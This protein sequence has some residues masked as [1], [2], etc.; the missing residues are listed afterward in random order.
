MYKTQIE[1]ILTHM[2]KNRQGITSLQSYNIYNITR[3]GA[4]IYDLKGKGYNIS[5]RWI[6]KTNNDGVKTRFKQYYLKPKGDC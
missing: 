6:E 3:L 4:R 5:D 2:Q 1:S